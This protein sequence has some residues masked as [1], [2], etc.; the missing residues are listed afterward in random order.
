MDDWIDIRADEAH[1]R[2]EREKA[3]QLRKTDWWRSL[4][5]KGECYYCHKIVGQEALT[6]DHKIP[7]SRGG[8]STRGNC[9]PCC[10]DCNNEKK[11]YTPVERILEG[12]FPNDADNMI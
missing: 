11:A 3:R 4:L 5:Q 7:V 9:V 2:R 1:V 6:M 8:K 10:K 12:L